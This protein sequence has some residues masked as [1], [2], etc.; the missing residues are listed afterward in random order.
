[1][2]VLTSAWQALYPNCR[3]HPT[4]HLDPEA[5]LSGERAT[6]DLAGDRT[7]ST[8]DPLST[9]QRSN[10]RRRHHPLRLCVV[11]EEQ[12]FD[13]QVQRKIH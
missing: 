2:A 8:M 1:M 9:N 6:Q 3:L 7:L 10:H 4:N 12:D 5:N 13:G 11:V